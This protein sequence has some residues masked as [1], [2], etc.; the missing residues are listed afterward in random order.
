MKV[1]LNR[2]LIIMA[3]SLMQICCRSPFG[4]EDDKLVI[5]NN[6]STRL[7]VYPQIN[8]PDTSIGSYNP[9]KNKTAY[10][11]LPNSERRIASRSWDQA[12]TRSASD[13]LMM[14]FY[15]ADMVDT[16]DWDI[17]VSDYLVLKRYDLSLEDL[18]GMNW[19]ITYP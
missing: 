1:S 13:T 16:T 4:G 6:S 12:V 15:D 17:V 14:F 8:H 2:I 11:V 18:Q 19:T 9:S 10:E 5:V 3:L 7:Y